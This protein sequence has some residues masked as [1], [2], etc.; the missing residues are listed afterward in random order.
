MAASDYEEMAIVAPRPVPPSPSRD[1]IKD[2]LQASKEDFV[3]E[4]RDGNRIVR[5]ITWLGA[6][7]LGYH[8]NVRILTLDVK[9]TGDAYAAMAKAEWDGRTSFGGFV[10]PKLIKLREGGTREDPAAYQ[11]AMNKAQ[12]NA[13]LN[14]LP[15]P[16]TIVEEIQI[17]QVAPAPKEVTDQDVKSWK[18]RSGTDEE[19]AYVVKRIRSK[20]GEEVWTCSCP[21]YQ[22]R[23]TCTHIERITGEL[24]KAKE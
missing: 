12:R 24:A 14:L 18:V 17:G 8:F 15:I 21:G 10:Q 1:R 2:V 16:K 20:D 5:G 7:A 3:Y 22:F 4:Y 19:T 23:G 13:I 11:K 6:R 9:D